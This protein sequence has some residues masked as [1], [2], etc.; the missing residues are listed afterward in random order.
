MI[1]E[2]KPLR[3]RTLL[4]SRYAALGNSAESAPEYGANI[5]ELPHQSATNSTLLNVSLNSSLFSVGE[6]T[7]TPVLPP[8][9]LWQS[10]LIALIIGIC[11]ILTVG[12]NILVL[13]AFFV[14]RTIR[15]PSNYFIASLACTD[16]FI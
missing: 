7:I 3:E 11:I 15:Q 9:E 5:M 2:C 14:D 12:G 8:F 16:I 6:P 10:I 1:G 13:L 4:R